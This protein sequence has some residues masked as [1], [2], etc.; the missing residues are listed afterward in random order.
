MSDEKIVQGGTTANKNGKIFEEQLV[1]LF[2]RNGYIVIK[3]SEWKEDEALI[4]RIKARIGNTKKTPKYYRH[5]PKLVICQYPYSS[6]YEHNGKTEFLI[7]NTL[8][9]QVIRVECK[10]QQAS[11]SVDEK[12]PY[13]YLNC[14]F[15]FEETEII[16]IIDG[17]GF[18]KGSKEWLQR[19][20]AERWLQ[21]DDKKHIQVM[22]ISEFTAY[23]NRNLA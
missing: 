1:P 10:W 8:K 18:K 5:E 13:L 19:K 3:H 2:Q 21:N 15:S 7:I 22:S 16:L 20:I 11:G 12:F 23:F 14:I 6:I 4:E 9:N 17:G